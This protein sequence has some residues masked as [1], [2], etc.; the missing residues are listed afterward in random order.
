M[1]LLFHIQIL[2]GTLL[3]SLRLEGHVSPVFH[4]LLQGSHRSST[5]SDDVLTSWLIFSTC[6]VCLAV[7]LLSTTHRPYEMRE[8]LQQRIPR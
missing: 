4:E 5:V 7:P 2:K 8:P 3:L 6:R 1:L